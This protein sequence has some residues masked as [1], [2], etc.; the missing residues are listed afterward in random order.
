[1]N[2]NSI[3]FPTCPHCDVE[4]NTT[5]IFSMTDLKLSPYFHIKKCLNT[6]CEKKFLM[7]TEIRLTTEV[8]KYEVSK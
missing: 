3:K 8:E 7:K 2:F 5:D 4:M 1:M 6:K